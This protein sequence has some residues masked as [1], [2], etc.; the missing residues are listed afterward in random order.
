[1]HMYS[2]HCQWCMHMSPY[3]ASGVYTCTP[4]T[5]SGVCTCTPYTASGVCTCLHTLP[6]AYAPVLH[7][8]PVVYAHV[9]HTPPV[10]CKAEGWIHLFSVGSFVVQSGLC[11]EAHLDCSKLNAAV[12]FVC[13][14]ELGKL[15][16][17][18]AILRFPLPNVECGSEPDEED[19]EE[20]NPAINGD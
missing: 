4:Y 3:T 13:V 10:V 14:A 20:E 12:Y 5:A 6:V 11:L 15:S 17:V 9:L 16:G 2:I 8:P 1:M 7:T 19:D 18:V